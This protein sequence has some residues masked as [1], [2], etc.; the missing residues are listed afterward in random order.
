MASNT[1]NPINILD[2]S[3]AEGL[4]SGGSLNVAGGVSISKNLYI[5]GGISISGTTTTFADNIII[6]NKRVPKPIKEKEKNYSIFDF[7]E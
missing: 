7:E 2:T 4:G 3:D 5:G 1:F 6:I